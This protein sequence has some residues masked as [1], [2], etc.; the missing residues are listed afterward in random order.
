MFVGLMETAE[1]ERGAIA[2]MEENLPDKMPFYRFFIEKHPRKENLLR[3]IAVES[4]IVVGH[5][6]I[7]PVWF[8]TWFGEFRGGVVRFVTAHREYDRKKIR[9]LLLSKAVDVAAR[10][11]MVFLSFFGEPYHPT[12]HGYTYVFPDDTRHPAITL[13]K[14][15]LTEME[16]ASKGGSITMEIRPATPGDVEDMVEIY[17]TANTSALP[18]SCGNTLFLKRDRIYWIFQEGLNVLSG[19]KTFVFTKKKGRA[20]KGKKSGKKIKGHGDGG[21]ERIVGYARL[22]K[23]KDLF[24]VGELFFRGRHTKKKTISALKLL[25]SEMGG[26][27]MGVCLP[28]WHPVMSQVKKQGNWKEMGY[29]RIVNFA[30]AMGKLADRMFVS[31]KTAPTR[32]VFDSYE[33][34][35]VVDI[36]E[37][38]TLALHRTTPSHAYE[39]S[40][41]VR[42]SP[43][44]WTRLFAGV[45]CFE[46]V[47]DL[48][49]TFFSPD[50]EE[51]MQ[52]VFS[53][54]G[55][56][57][58]EAKNK[59]GP[60]LY[61]L[62]R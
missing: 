6:L 54:P 41:F 13:R 2:L 58:A 4:G 20:E 46:E 53:C 43:E 18:A 27:E 29:L 59:K 38:G 60:Y 22:H 56:G 30:K 42:V 40:S 39:G 44:A 61:Y 52:K 55:K 51:L 49:D 21:E 47:R 23:N 15:A 35:V 14:R 7:E 5:L 57:G 37:D 50:M 24:C 12:K 8:S 32:V 62:D 19:G 36:G 11:G 33:D 16:K 34:A 25:F 3:L 9:E 1:E 28:P 45:S 17:S 26:E 31:E 48:P 10:E